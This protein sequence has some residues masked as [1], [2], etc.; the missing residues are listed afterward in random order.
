MRHV[1]FPDAAMRNLDDNRPTLW[2]HT[3]PAVRERL[4]VRVNSGFGPARVSSS[5]RVAGVAELV[6]ANASHALGRKLVRVRI[7]PPAPAARRPSIA[8]DPRTRYIGARV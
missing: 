4:W 6:D 7:P 3:T 2:W 1:R 5:F 8:S